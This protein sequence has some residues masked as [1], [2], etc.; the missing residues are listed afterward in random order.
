LLLLARARVASD[1]FA[2]AGPLLEQA[3]A[4]SGDDLQ[5]RAEVMLWL[6]RYYARTDDRGRSAQIQRRLVPLAEKIGDPDL[7]AD[8]LCT[9]ARIEFLLGN[10]FGKTTFERA[11]RLPSSSPDPLHEAGRL[12]FVSTLLS[13]GELDEARSQLERLHRWAVERGNEFRLP[14]ILIASAE[15]EFRAG[16]WL[17]AT[18]L[19]GDALE[20]AALNQQEPLRI[21]T[22]QLKA[23]IAAHRGDVAEARALAAEALA[24]ASGGQALGADDVRHRSILGFLALSQGNSAEA[25]ELLRKLPERRHFTEIEEPTIYGE[26]PDLIESAIAEGEAD[27]ARRHVAWLEK[28]GQ[29]LDRAWALAS[30]ARYRAL[31]EASEGT[32]DAALESAGEALAE[33]QKL[34][35]PFERARTLLVRG[36]VQRR[37]K[38]RRA[39]RQSLSQALDVFDELGAR[40]WADRTRAELARIGGRASGDELT[41]TEAQVAAR[42]AAGETNREIAE[43]LFMSVKTVEANLS[44]VYRKLDISSRR[45]LGARLERQT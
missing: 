44:R 18:E 19:A 31:I 32:L 38:K 42:A 4:E 11:L 22:L 3:I 1:G 2:Q 30:A 9:L 34:P 16:H 8:C 21:E 40:L 33:Q 5:L 41:P 17:R 36:V 14:P 24:T 23:T 29:T 10:G 35:L 26:L 15:L 25:L 37:A 28:R 7:L 12:N 13:V 27:L 39:A 43:A 45:Q 20:A 6:A